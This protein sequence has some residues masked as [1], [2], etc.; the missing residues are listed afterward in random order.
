MTHFMNLHPQPFSNIADGTKTIELRLFDEKRKRISVGDT[1]IFKNTQ[2]GSKTL[3]CL[4]TKLHIFSDFEEL[5]AALPLVKCGYLPHELA[6]ASA[7]DME[8]Y[9]PMEKQK[10]FGV[11]GIE[12][13]LIKD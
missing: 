11:V 9:Y 7:K 12:I 6:S 13:R 5:Y 8:V 10:N 2:D 1:I 3:S 4:V